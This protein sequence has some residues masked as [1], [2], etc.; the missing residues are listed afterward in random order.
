VG[1]IPEAQIDLVRERADIVQVIGERLRLTQKGQQFW[2]CCPFHEEKSASFAVNPGMQIFKCFGCQKGG[3]VFQFIT[4]YEHISFPEAVRLVAERVGIELEESGGNSGDG[5]RKRELFEINEIVRSYY[6]EILW[7][8]AGE[9][10]RGYLKERGLSDEVARRFHLGLAAP[11]WDNLLRFARRKGLEDASLVHLGLVVERADS[12]RRYDRFRDRLMFPIHDP[13]GRVLAFGGR[14]F[15]NDP[16]VPK[17]INSAEVPGL[18]EKRRVLYGIDQARRARAERLVIVEGYTDAIAAAQAGVDGVVAVLGTAFGADH[19]PL[20]K[21]FAKEVVVLFDG[22]LA[23]RAAAR[24]SLG[25]LVPVDLDVRVAI[26]DGGQDP[27]DFIRS[28]GAEAFTALISGALEA[29]EFLLAAVESEAG[30]NLTRRARAIDELLGLLGSMDP[31]RYNLHIARI[32][33]RFGLNEGDLRSRTRSLA[34]TP[35]P[36]RREAPR[37][38]PL[39]AD[40]DPRRAGKGVELRILEALLA[41]PGRAGEVF[42][43]LTP[44][45]FSSGPVRVLATRLQIAA[46]LG[47][48]LSP[49]SLFDELDPELLPLAQYLVGLASEGVEHGKDYESY[50]EP[51]AC[52]RLDQSLGKAQRKEVRRQ[53]VAAQQDGDF[54]LLQELEAELEALMEEQAQGERERNAEAK[55]EEA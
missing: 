42:S 15:G 26:L 29:F 16:E 47:R 4:E 24:R 18:F 55:E 27:F 28:Q 11:G 54:E 25:P 31:L 12:G 51:E 1:R 45:H 33:Q 13:Q 9:K 39:S 40:Y 41:A 20:V 8:A 38:E 32:A 37:E 30:T 2:A 43:L 10:G 34:S 46:D 5:R 23:G 35:R 19:V 48:P 21:R 17:Y 52:A 7:G 44:R 3:N 49:S 6:E 53:L 22:D 50:L 36:R 14:R